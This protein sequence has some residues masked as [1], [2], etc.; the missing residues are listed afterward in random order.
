MNKINV[1]IKRVCALDSMYS[2]FLYLLLSTEEEIKETFFFFGSSISEDAKKM[3]KEQSYFVPS[4]HW[5]VFTELFI[6]AF[7]YYIYYPL[8]FPFLLNSKV[9]KWSGH[10]LWECAVIR[11]KPY[12]ALEDG[13][14]N[15]IPYTKGRFSKI[16]TLLFGP[17]FRSTAYI[18]TESTCKTLF[19]TGMIADSVVTRQS[20]V[21][22]IKLGDL[23][24][25]S[26]ESKKDNILKIFGIS[27]RELSHLKQYKKL[28]LTQPL[29]DPTSNLMTEQEKICFYQSFFNLKGTKGFLIKPHPRESTNYRLYFPQM[30]VFDT[31]I[32]FEVMSF[33]GITFQEV[34]TVSSTAI[35]DIPYNCDIFL[36]CSQ[37]TSK[38]VEV[39]IELNSKKQINVKGIIMVDKKE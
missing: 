25:S 8:R 18:G 19:L 38:L 23:W 6:L 15:Y 26:E 34:Y 3:F 14:L 39:L 28:L 5:S 1:N 22:I 36:I 20:N 32:P 13:L 24:E 10:T 21:K 4:Y 35:F 17:T 7:L 31:K 30:G 9:E 29:D 33:L 2:L 27:L 16:K 12:C 11:R 37:K